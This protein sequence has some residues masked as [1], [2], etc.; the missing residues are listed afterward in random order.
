MKK[1]KRAVISDSDSDGE[2]AAPVTK[3]PSK[4][5]VKEAKAEAPKPKLKE[6]NATDFF[7]TNSKESKTELTPSKKRKEVE[8]SS[9]PA[10]SPN[11][12]TTSVPFMAGSPSLPSRSVPFQPPVPELPLCQY[13]STSSTTSAVPHQSRVDP[14]LAPNKQP[15]TVPVLPSTSSIVSKEVYAKR[16][17]AIKGTVSKKGSSTS[18]KRVET[19]SA[20]SSKTAAPAPVLNPRV[21]IP[22]AAP[23]RL[24]TPLTEGH[25]FSRV[26]VALQERQAKQEECLTISATVPGR[27]VAFD[28]NKE[29]RRIGEEREV[30]QVA[31]YV[32]EE[33]HQFGRTGGD[34]AEG[35]Q[36]TSFFLIHDQF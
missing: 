34:G 5:S 33:F 21:A 36:V 14:L 15:A 24:P 23:T 8:K 13:L 4:P 20:A 27:L 19:S 32:K 29:G 6:I 25:S 17:D 22:L 11:V 18:S 28:K 3:K 2:T 1:K 12:P 31:A 7:A 10:S 35:L 26:V 30:K 16:T 9:A